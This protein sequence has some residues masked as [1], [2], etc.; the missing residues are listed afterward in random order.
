MTGFLDLVRHVDEWLNGSV[1]PLPEQ[2]IR[3]FNAER[4]RKVA[5]VFHGADALSGQ[6][7]LFD[8][9]DFSFIPIETPLGHLR[10]IPARDHQPLG[11]L[12][13]TDARRVLYARP[14]RELHA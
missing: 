11:R 7:P 3:E 5:S 14:A 2:K 8:I 1:F 10:T 6:L 13:R 9:Y 4:L 12:G